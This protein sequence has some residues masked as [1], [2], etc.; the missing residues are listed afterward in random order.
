[1]RRWI[2]S[3]KFRKQRVSKNEKGKKKEKNR[4]IGDLRKKRGFGIQSLAVGNEDDVVGVKC[5]IECKL[6]KQRSFP[7]EH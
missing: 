2:N 3:L 7:T 6:K 5:Y 1:M 4:E